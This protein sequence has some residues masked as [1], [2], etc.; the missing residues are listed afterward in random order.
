MKVFVCAIKKRHSD[1]RCRE[2]E[3]V[4]QLV[5]RMKTRSL[6]CSKTYFH[7]KRILYQQTSGT[8]FFHACHSRFHALSPLQI[9]FPTIFFLSSLPSTSYIFRYFLSFAFFFPFPSIP[10]VLLQ[11]TPPPWYHSFEYRLFF[12]TVFIIFLLKYRYIFNLLRRIFPPFF[13][14]LVSVYFARYCSCVFSIVSP[15]GS[16]DESST[17]NKSS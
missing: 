16:N 5:T 13:P 12:S 4:A 6:R 9:N 11:R 7:F 10:P 14:R 1:G 17:F 15:P 8:P 3:L 2:L